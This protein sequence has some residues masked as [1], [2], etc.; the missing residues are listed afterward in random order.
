MTSF[1]R[2][3]I[4]VVVEGRY[5]GW[6]SIGTGITMHANEAHLFN[7]RDLAE[8]RLETYLKQPQCYTSAK[9][10]DVTVTMPEQYD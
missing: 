2:Y 5:S 4:S 7:R 1:T 8:K 3:A 6:H 9:I 10:V